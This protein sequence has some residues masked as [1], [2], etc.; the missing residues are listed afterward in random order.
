MT[1]S[2]RSNRR[3]ILVLVTVVVALTAGCGGPPGLAGTKTTRTYCDNGGVDETLD[4]YQPAVLHGRAPTVVYIHGGGWVSGDSTLQAGTVEGEV[5]STLSGRGWVFVSIN[6]RLAPASRWPAQIVDAKCAI[7]YVRA[8]A[9]V[10]HV[11]PSRIAVMGA[12]AGGHLASMVGLTGETALFIEGANP[13]VSS[14]VDEVVDEYGP[15]DLTTPDWA[16]SKVVPLFVKETFGEPVGQRSPALVAASPATYVHPH[17]PP[18]LVVQGADD[19]IVPPSQ[20]QLLVAALGTDG[21]SASLIWVRN[22]GHGLIPRGDGPV[23]PSIPMVVADIVDFLT[24]HQAPSAEV[25]AHH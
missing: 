19:E 20:S 12:S 16:D 21:D 1:C 5:E 17:A 7:R 24:T 22:A 9:A 6:Y 15:A 25:G 8:N 18:F 23:T 3:P 10:L 2:P 4:V 13:D 11:D 14:A